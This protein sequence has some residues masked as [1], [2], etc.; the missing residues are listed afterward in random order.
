M[1]ADGARKLSE[2]GV[3]FCDIRLGPERPPQRQYH[4]ANTLSWRVAVATAG[5]VH[6]RAR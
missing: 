6:F 5:H 4:T 2:A 3:P 1:T